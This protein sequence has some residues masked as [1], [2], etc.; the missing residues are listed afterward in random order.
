[1][2]CP[3]PEWYVY[4]ENSNAKTIEKFNVFH[5]YRFMDCCKKAFKKYSK[6]IDKLKKEIESSALYSFWSKCEY[7]IVLTSWISSNKDFKDVRIDVYEQ[8]MLN[9]NAFIQ[10]TLD[11]KAF[12]LRRDK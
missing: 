3:D 5:S 1:M 10:Y 12:F 9:W 11:H 2:K 7:E 4:C 6:D 8:L